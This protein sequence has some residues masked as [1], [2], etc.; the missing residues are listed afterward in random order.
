[1]TVKNITLAFGRVLTINAGRAFAATGTCTNGGQINVAGTFTCGTLTGAGN[2]NFNGTTAQNLPALTF[3]NLD[4]NNAAGVTLLGN[5]TINGI[6]NLNSGIVNTGVNTLV[7]SASSSA[8]RSGTCAITSCFVASSAA[9]GGVQKVFA[10]GAN[11]GF[12]FLVGTTGGTDNGYTP[13]TLA[14]VTAGTAGD[15]L[16]V[17][18]VDAVSPATIAAEKITRYWQLTEGGDVTTDLTFRYLDADDNAVTAPTA[19]RVVRNSA[20]MCPT[21]CVN[22]ATFTGTVTGVSDFSPWTI[23]ALAPTAAPAPVSGRVLDRDGRGV[24][25]AQVAIDDGNGNV[26]YATTN[27]FGYYRFLNL[28]AGVTY[29]A[30]V[31]SKRH[32]FQPRVVNLGEEISDVDF[33]AEP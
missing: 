26:R 13:V 28:P 27:P 16:T 33:V 5:V 29:I 20:G 24:S 11:P 9:A 7:F 23:A 12:V 2:V 25:G 19:L 1:V 17:R 15:S 21:D 4:I 3:N 6:F 18:S 10:A 30:R 32:T 31:A 14:N 22:E 8:F